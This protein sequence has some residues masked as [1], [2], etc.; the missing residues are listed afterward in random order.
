MKISAPPELGV[1]GDLKRTRFD[2]KKH[3]LKTPKSNNH[4]NSTQKPFELPF[5][6]PLF[7]SNGPDREEGSFMVLPSEIGSLRLDRSRYAELFPIR[8]I[9][10]SGE[11]LVWQTL[12][13]S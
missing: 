3:H 12:N 8:S 9:Y 4:L 10:Q 2:L 6:H 13:Q 11:E 5:E 7:K 1:G